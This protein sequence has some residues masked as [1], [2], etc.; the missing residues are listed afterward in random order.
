MCNNTMLAVQHTVENAMNV[1]EMLPKKFHFSVACSIRKF[2]HVV[3]IH[4][5]LVT[6]VYIYI[7]LKMLVLTKCFRVIVEDEKKCVF[8]NVRYMFAN[9][10]LLVRCFIFKLTFRD[11]TECYCF[12][13]DEENS[14]SRNLSPEL[15]T[16]RNRMIFIQYIPI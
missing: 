2:W 9:C 4:F 3:K 16:L 7:I 5:Q 10:I 11:D 6:F 15:R 14:Y 8:L 12:G 13:L 1:I